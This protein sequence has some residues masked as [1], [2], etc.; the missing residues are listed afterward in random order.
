MRLAL[1]GEEILQ[2]QK[3]QKRSMIAIFFTV[4][5]DLVGFGM[6]IPVLVNVA[7]DF[8]A[9]ATESAGVNTWYSLGTFLAV[10]FLGRL[11]DT[12]GRKPLLVGSIIVSACA[13]L[14]TGFA[15][16][17][18]LLSC[19]RFIGGAAAGNISVAQ[20][21]IADITSHKTRA[22]SMVLIGLAFGGGFAIGPA[23]GAVISRLAP[24][25]TMQ[26]ISLVA[27]SLN[28]VNLCFV[29]RN[30][31][32]THPSFASEELKH[33]Q[34]T[35][36]MSACDPN[37]PQRSLPCQ[38]GLIGDFAIL[39][40]TPQLRSVFFMQFLQIFGFVGLETILPLILRED[41][42]FAS[43]RI[44]DTFIVLGVSVLIL[45]G[46]VAR[47]LLKHVSEVSAIRLGQFLLCGGIAGVHLAAP[48]AWGLYPALILIAA[49]TSFTNPAVS[50]L[51]SQMCRREHTGLSFGALQMV[52]ASARIV[53]PVTIGAA[54]QF[55]GDT[56]SLW[57]PVGL[58][59]LASLLSLR[60]STGTSRPPQS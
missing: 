36:V 19:A 41:Y 1:V 58:I 37:P 2:S 11:S 54:Y 20:S 12:Y 17:L 57:L 26:A 27:F 25:S 9:T 31:P 43:S 59:G 50:S 29:V 55:A 47:Q 5:L 35:N 30:L 32:E 13:H 22:R 51:T 53:G 60:L 40:Q 10:L 46:L 18:I 34:E 21:V 4:F 23:L 3:L 6:F 15:P 52:A 14:A 24:E 8:G 48:N 44:F 42:G 38:K 7:R 16:N 39:A 45:N 56:R 49:G 28:L 33:L